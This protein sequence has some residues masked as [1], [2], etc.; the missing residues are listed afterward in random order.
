MQI[1]ISL[2]PIFIVLGFSLIAPLILIS[3][4]VSRPKLAL[5]IGTVICF[6]TMSALI[7]LSIY[8]LN[9]A[10]GTN[11]D[12]PLA[13]IY[14]VGIMALIFGLPVLT[15]V[16]WRSHRKQKRLNQKTINETF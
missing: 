14:G 6:L 13:A 5:L 9:K 3:K 8:V 12:V 4:W 15:L 11:V 1:L 16:Q 2:F 10:D 7:V